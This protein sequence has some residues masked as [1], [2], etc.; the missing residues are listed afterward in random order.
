MTDHALPKTSPPDVLEAASVATFLAEAVEWWSAQ[1]KGRGQRR[2]AAE[3][4][5]KLGTLTH[6]LRGTRKMDPAHAEVIGRV[7][8]LDGAETA[9]LEQM[10]RCERNPEDE[11]AAYELD[12][13]QR[14]LRSHRLGPRDATFLERWSTAA[15]RELARTEGF[16][17]EPGWVAERLRPQI[18][19]QE[20]QD[21]LTLL[22][23]SRTAI[24]DLNE[25]VSTGLVAS[26]GLAPDWHEQ[27][28]NV[29]KEGA[30]LPKEQ[31]YYQS[32]IGAVS[33]D[34]VPLLRAA[35]DRFINEVA[36]ICETDRPQPRDRVVQVSLQLVPLTASSDGA[37]RLFDAGAASPPG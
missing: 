28:L 7:L 37:G 22:A 36:G 14:M 24:G 1:A 11:R 18:S 26:A 33:A 13:R 8:E 35:V 23:G 17:A 31:R 6:M 3:T 15:L 4:G 27:L 21:A 12:G 16:R 5:I 10:A 29:A 19:V 25:I 2:F 9:V 20:A 30:T 32:F 34:A